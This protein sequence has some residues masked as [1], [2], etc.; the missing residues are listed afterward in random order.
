M[1]DSTLRLP[2]TPRAFSVYLLGLIIV[3]TG[4]FMHVLVA[5]QIMQAEFRLSQLQEEYRSLEQQNGDIIFQIARDTNMARLHERV[6]AQGYVPVQEREYIFAPSE[7][8][9]IDTQPQDD[10]QPRNDDVGST[11]MAA[12]TAVAKSSSEPVNGEQ[13]LVMH[14]ANLGGQVARW[15]EF[16][17][18][19][20]RTAFGRANAA[21]SVT[22]APAAGPAPS[23]A[24]SS[25]QPAQ[26]PTNFW[27]VWWEQASEQGSKL[28]NQVRSQ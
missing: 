2:S 20:W 24:A 18:V 22:T 21:P 28:I 13:P 19:I 16:W 26:A 3:F 8:V 5:A 15:E 10:P 11:E 25:A 1:L 9:A 4:A 6:L 17:G 14:T 12:S 23:V 27:S 7:I